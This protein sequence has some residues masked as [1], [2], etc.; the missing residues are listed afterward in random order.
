MHDRLAS[1]V[2][3]KIWSRIVEPTVPGIRELKE[4][5]SAQLAAKDKWTDPKKSLAVP[6]NE[7]FSHWENYWNTNIFVG[8]PPAL[9]DWLWVESSPGTQASRGVEIFVPGYSDDDPSSVPTD[10]SIQ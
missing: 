6:F 4:C 1:L 2:P 7:R 8:M 9:V 5:I 3:S 10:H